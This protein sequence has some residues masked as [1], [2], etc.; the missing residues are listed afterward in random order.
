MDTDG[1]RPKS[2][3]EI[4]LQRENFTY[5]DVRGGAKLKGRNDRARVGPHHVAV[6]LKFTQLIKQVVNFTIDLA[7]VDAAFLFRRQI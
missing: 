4:V 6:D 1:L 7:L 5:F 2:H 3:R